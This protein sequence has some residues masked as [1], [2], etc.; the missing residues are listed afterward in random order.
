MH[1]EEPVPTDPSRPVRRRYAIAAAIGAV[2]ATLAAVYFAVQHERAENSEEARTAAQRAACAYGPTM[3][4]YDAEHLDTYFAAVLDGATGDW[5]REFDSTSKDLREV[6]VQGRVVS[7]AD[8]V[9]CAIEKSDED[10]AEA[11]LVIGQTITSAGTGNQPRPG[12]LAITL[13]LRKVG[14]DW[15]VDKVSSPLLPPS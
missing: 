5:K 11:V 3:A 8:S 1:D 13:S 15:L 7:K 2:P 10:T 6:L 14:D 12:Q 4:T 9:Q